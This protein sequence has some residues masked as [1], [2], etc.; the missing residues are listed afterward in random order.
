[1]MP[2]EYLVVQVKPHEGVG[3]LSGKA[4]KMVQVLHWDAIELEHLGVEVVIV[5]QRCVTRQHLHQVCFESIR[6]FLSGSRGNWNC[7]K[8][9]SETVG[10]GG[11]QDI[12]MQPEYCHEISFM[13]QNKTL[14]QE[15]VAN[16]T[17]VTN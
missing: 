4:R 12:V 10:I 2:E 7:H 16:V 5:P 8:S 17:Y 3:A 14:R 15:M 13:K 11:I 6:R 9:N 1:M